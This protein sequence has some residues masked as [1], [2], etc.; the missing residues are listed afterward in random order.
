[1][2]V[3]PEDAL[4]AQ[5]AEIPLER[6][7]PPASVTFFANSGFGP[8]PYWIDASGRSSVVCIVVFEFL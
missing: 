6:A 4:D 1:M 3:A 5:G 2:G 7:N 8:R